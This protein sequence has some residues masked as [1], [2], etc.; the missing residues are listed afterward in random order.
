MREASEGV[1]PG[2]PLRTEAKVVK[3]P[4]RF[5]DARGA[6]M[7]ETVCRLMDEGE[8]W[9]MLGVQGSETCSGYMLGVHAGS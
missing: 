2:F 6:E 8:E 7:W 4:Q 5:K 9:N 3:Y 1:L